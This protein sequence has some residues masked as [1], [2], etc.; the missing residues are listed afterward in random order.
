MLSVTP[1]RAFFRPG[2]PIGLLVNS[3]IP[4]ET[5]ITADIYHLGDLITK[6]SVQMNGSQAIITGNVPSETRRGYLV[7]VRLEDQVASTAFDVLDHWTQAPRYGFLYDF[8]ADRTESDIEATFDYLLPFHVNGLQFYDW[9]YRHDTLLPPTDEYSDPLGRHLSLN[10]V[11]ALIT[12]AHRYGMAAMPYTAIYAASPQFAETHLPWAL[13][14]ADHQPFDFASGFLKIMNPDS[15]WRAHFI[16]ECRK[17]LAALPFDGIHVDQYGE[18]QTGFDVDGKTV[19]LPNSFAELLTELRRAVGLQKDV[20]FNLVHN[21]PV[22][23]IANVPLNFWYSE[24]WP[25]N[26][27][28]T[29][30]WQTLRDNHKLNPRPAVLAVYIRPDWEETIC[31]A[32]SVILASGGTQIIHGDHGR[33]LSD[34][35]FPKAGIPSPSLTHRL[36][37]L[38]DFAVAYEEALVFAEDATDDWLPLLQLEGIADEPG[39]V[40]VR[41]AGNNLYISLLNVSGQWNTELSAPQPLK[42]VRLTIPGHTIS[43]SWCA[44]PEAPLAIPV[45]IDQLPAIDSW[46]LI[47]LTLEELHI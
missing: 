18:P 5:L 39:Q 26:T 16:E 43:R 38:A 11:R 15:G 9:Q 23:A 6:W 1:T 28:L 14:D 17:V 12:A 47:G 24:L 31:A 40:I 7:R 35:Y 29:H 45:A 25:P 42:N 13:Y 30:L 32:N 46:L 27:T 36:R 20:L 33:Y 10:T 8:S 21:W 3:T 19:D 22:S 41:A 44:S 34:P 4:L 37:Q 2:E